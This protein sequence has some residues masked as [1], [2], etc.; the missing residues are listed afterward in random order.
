MYIIVDNNR[1][2]TYPHVVD[3]IYHIT[4][5][6]NVL[7]YDNTTGATFKVPAWTLSKIN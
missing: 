4:N 3:L 2:M 1:E 7:V 6:N 5:S